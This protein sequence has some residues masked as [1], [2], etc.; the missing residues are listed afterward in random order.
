MR[1]RDVLVGKRSLAKAL[2]DDIKS[3]IMG[4]GN[5]TELLAKNTTDVTE[6]ITKMVGNVQV[7]TSKVIKGVTGGSA[8]LVASFTETLAKTKAFAQ[9]LKD[10]RALGLDSNIYQ[11]IVSAGVDAGGTTAKAILEG[12]AGTVSELNGL[13]TELSDVGAAMA[14]EAAQVMYGSGIDLVDGLING[15]ISK[16]Q[17]LVN[18]ATQLATAFTTAFNSQLATALPMPNAPV[19]PVYV[20]PTM[21]VEQF[22]KLRLGDVKLGG[23]DAKTTALASKLIAKKEFTAWTTTINVNAGFGT[24]GKATGQAVYTELKKFAKANGITV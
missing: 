24:D 2:M 18:Y 14:E 5:V 4:M 8:G 15:L 21:P 9:Q 23:Y 19:E 12:G 10:L 6:T 17:E 11:Q 1:Q 22:Q 13:F 20:E 7:A 3:T 16:E